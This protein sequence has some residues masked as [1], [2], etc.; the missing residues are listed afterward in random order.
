MKDDHQQHTKDE[1]YDHVLLK[2]VFPYSIYLPGNV[3]TYKHSNKN[4]I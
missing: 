4:K 3:L 2:V 1:E